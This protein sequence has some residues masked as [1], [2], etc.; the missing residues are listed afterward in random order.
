MDKELLEMRNGL[1]EKY[2]ELLLGETDRELQKKVESWILY[3]HVAKSMPA[4]AKHWNDKYPEGKEAM[5]AIIQEIK[6]LNE[7]HRQQNK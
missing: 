4:L 1:L 7:T 2:T 3:T 6:E 5:K